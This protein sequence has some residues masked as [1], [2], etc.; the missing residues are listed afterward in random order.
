[1]PM[2]KKGR[3]MRVAA[4]YANTMMNATLSAPYAPS[5]FSLDLGY[6]HKKT[7]MT[8]RTIDIVPKIR[9]TD[10]PMQNRY[11]ATRFSNAAALCR[12]ME[13]KSGVA[14][15]IVHTWAIPNTINDIAVM[16]IDIIAV[17]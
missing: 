9:E 16:A 17:A 13:R 7:M 8:M 12:A 6:F 4:V 2:N 1:M 3:A 11:H 15:T 5:L 10:A 14:G